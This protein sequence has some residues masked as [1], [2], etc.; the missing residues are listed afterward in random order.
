MAEGR[1]EYPIEH[2]AIDIPESSFRER[3][4]VM[5]GNAMPKLIIIPVCGSCAMEFERDYIDHGNP[6]EATENILNDSE[7]F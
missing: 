2:I 1:I 7:W 3:I 5:I 4:M 6:F